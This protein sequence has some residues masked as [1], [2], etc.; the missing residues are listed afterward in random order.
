MLNCPTDLVLLQVS[1]FGW[2]CKKEE[3]LGIAA[4]G[5]FVGHMNPFLLF[6]SHFQSS[7]GILKRCYQLQIKWFETSFLQTG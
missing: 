4:A 6:N 7:E 1:G 5:S 3:P 2:V